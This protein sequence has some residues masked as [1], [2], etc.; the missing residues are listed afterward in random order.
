MSIN[1]VPKIFF[2]ALLASS[3]FRFAFAGDDLMF[4]TKF[5]SAVA[6]VRNG[7]TATI[8]TEAAQHLAELTGK[9]D[10]KSVDDAA[11]R[12]L[13][14][15]LDSNEDSVRMWV[16]GSLGNLGPRAKGAVPKLLEL[17]P[18]ADRLRGSLTSAPAIRLA[19]T[20]IGVNPPAPKP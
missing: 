14:C 16:A 17:L 4:K 1:S 13:I 20:K 9:V 12:E 15:L 8:R 6:G 3:F 10:P 7:G 19:L 18:G 2:V 11:I 5:N